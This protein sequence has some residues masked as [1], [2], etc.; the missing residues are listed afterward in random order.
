MPITVVSVLQEGE[1][2]CV[3][4]KWVYSN[5]N[6]QIGNYTQVM[7]ICSECGRQELVNIPTINFNTLH[8]KFHS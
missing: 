1:E 6:M 2:N 7:R 5:N 4:D 8:I 3:C